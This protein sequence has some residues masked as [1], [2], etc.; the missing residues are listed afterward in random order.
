MEIRCKYYMYLHIAY[1]MC[2]KKRIY[3]YIFERIDSV[4][5][6]LNVDKKTKDKNKDRDIVKIVRSAPSPEWRK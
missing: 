5:C 6:K 1:F 3:T 4:E 2:K